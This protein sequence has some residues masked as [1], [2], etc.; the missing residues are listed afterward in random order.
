MTGKAPGAPA[1]P[2][3]APVIPSKPGDTSGTLSGR[4]HIFARRDQILVGIL[5]SVGL[6]VIVIHWARL[7]GWN[8]EGVAIEH[9]EGAGAF[10]IDVNRATWVEW[11]QLE[12]IGPVLAKRIVEDQK[13][14]GPFRTIDD[15]GRVSGIGPKRLSKL[16]P[17]LSIEERPT[18]A[19]EGLSAK[20]PG[21][22][23]PVAARR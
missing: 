7:G 20:A 21:M 14:N 19:A 10:R 8:L 2:G 17:W 18:V 1:K 13:K 6:A 3:N 9:P 23:D 15:V 11:A 22:S 16:R 4:R 12:G 5:V